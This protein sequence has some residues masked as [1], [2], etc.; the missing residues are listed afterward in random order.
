MKANPDDNVK[1]AVGA[2]PFS[3]LE[4]S[5]ILMTFKSEKI[6]VSVTQLTERGTLYVC[7]ISRKLPT[8]NIDGKPRKSCGA[9]YEWQEVAFPASLDE[10]Y[11]SKIVIFIK[12][13][14]ENPDLFCNKAM[15]ISYKDAIS[16]L[17][18]QNN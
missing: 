5:H 14:V 4:T 2:H 15:P 6:K 16:K 1:V 17:T 8:T 18:Q 13:M 9:S 12:K 7:L 10:K 11:V 3:S